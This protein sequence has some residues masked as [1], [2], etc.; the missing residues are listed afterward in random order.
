VR[1]FLAIPATLGSLVAVILLTAYLAQVFPDLDPSA[2]I[3]CWLLGTALWA[4]LDSGRIQLKKYKSGISFGPV[5][6]FLYLIFFWYIVM[7]WYLHTRYRITNGLAELK[8]RYAR[9]WP[10]LL[11]PSQWW[12]DFAGDEPS[13]GGWNPLAWLIAAL[14]A[15][16]LLWLAAE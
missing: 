14:I 15:F 9:P 13:L 2:P 11:R 5:V 7:P 1:W 8:D 4:T 10:R 16:I 6:L 3:A 12:G